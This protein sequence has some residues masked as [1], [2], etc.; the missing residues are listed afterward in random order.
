MNLIN[1]EK[2]YRYWRKLSEKDYQRIYRRCTKQILCLTKYVSCR[3]YECFNDAV[4]YEQVLEILDKMFIRKDNETV[5]RYLLTT[6]HYHPSKTYEFLRDLQC[7]FKDCTFTAVAAEQYRMENV[8]LTLSQSYYP[9]RILDL[10][11]HNCRNFNT[12]RLTEKKK[13]KNK[14]S[15]F[16][17]PISSA[18]LSWTSNEHLSSK[19]HVFFFLF[20]FVALYYILVH[21]AQRKTMVILRVESVTGVKKKK[22]SVRKFLSLVHSWRHHLLP[23]TNYYKC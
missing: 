8:N 9:H 23:F 5:T 11:T 3:V 4:R 17:P 14:L 1:S 2:E 13:K 21:H 19:A 7:L 12:T 16:F 20:F 22:I 6:R 18:G 10:P 15:H